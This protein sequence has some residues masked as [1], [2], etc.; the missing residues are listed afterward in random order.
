MSVADT[1]GDLAP[2]NRTQ[3]P[4]I[5]LRDISRTFGAIQ[6]LRDV[7][8]E[9]QQGDVVGLVGDNGAG[10]STLVKIL[11]GAD[12]PSSGEII[13]EGAPHQL[14]PPAQAQRLGIE[15][16][17][18]DL[19]LIGS[20]T[21]AENFF[22]G[23]EMAWG[24]GPVLFRWMRRAAMMEAAARGLEDL[25]I[26]I[27]SNP[28]ADRRS[29]VGRPATARRDRP[30]RLLGEQAASCS[31]SQLPRSASVNRGRFWTSSPG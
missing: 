28:Y 24:H 6:A 26:E 7:S 23:R 25:H 12:V 10:K 31:T 5:S 3:P 8:L 18:Q 21:V 15:T 13:L 19:S 29:Y 14:S 11:A 2:M 16:V 27:L 30:G 17:Y 4:L 20:F 1:M 9:L 22:L